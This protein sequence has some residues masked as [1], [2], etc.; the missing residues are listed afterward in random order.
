MAYGDLGGAVTELVITCKTPD[1]GTVAIG[2]GDAVKLTDAYTVDNATDADDAVFG[3][4]LAD[5]SANGVALPVKVRGVCIF[6]YTGATPPTVDGVQGVVAS[7]TDGKV[8][9]PSSGNGM[10]RN[11]KVDTSAGLVHVLL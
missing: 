1:S 7:D 10:G 11:I 4:A 6:G 9:A 2:R 8:A 3:Q 5:V